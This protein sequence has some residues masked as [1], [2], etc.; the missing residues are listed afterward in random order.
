MDD[1]GSQPPLPTRREIELETAL[2][3]RDAQVAELTNEVERLRQYLIQHPPLPS[4]T[5]P[6]PLP[7][8]IVST[9]LPHLAK[10]AGSGGTGG[11][12]QSS[13]VNTALTHRIRVLQEENDELY[14]ILRCG[15]TGKLKEEVKGLRHVVGRLESA[16]RESHQVITTLSTELDKSYQS[17]QSSFKPKHHANTHSQ[18][19]TAPPREPQPTSNGLSKLP[20]TGPRAHKKPRLSGDHNHPQVPTQP[21]QPHIK[22]ESSRSPRIPPADTR[23]KG[24]VKMEIE[25]DAR[26]RPR[27]PQGQR[28]KDRE[29]ERERGRD[30]ERER[31]RD[32][33]RERFSRRNGSGSRSAGGRT[34][35]RGALSHSYLSGDRT[36]A[37]R[38][39]L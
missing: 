26:T 35:N 6:V 14:E 38:M 1:D 19:Y 2:R 27:S 13:T 15:E 20:P 39:G 21:Q 11:S 25:E 8:S 18:P 22:H 10:A 31:D 4:A 37:E 34:R 29:R 30:R 23:L 9:L 3:K 24:N 12:P 7:P 33:D 17:F 36:L 28:E 5:D 16:L 32:R